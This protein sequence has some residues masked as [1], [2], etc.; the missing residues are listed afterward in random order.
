MINEECNDD[1]EYD[2]LNQNVSPADT[3][4]EFKDD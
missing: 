1:D 4:N 2:E 3:E